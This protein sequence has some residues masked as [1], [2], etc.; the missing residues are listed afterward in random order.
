MADKTPCSQ[1]SG[2][3][4]SP[5]LSL[6]E[7]D[8]EEDSVVAVPLEKREI[9][10]QNGSNSSPQLYRNNDENCQIEEN[11]PTSSSGALTCSNCSN[12]CSLRQTPKLNHISTAEAR[13]KSYLVGCA[14]SWGSLLGAGQLDLHFPERQ[15]SVLVGTWNTNEIGNLAST[16]DDFLLPTCLKQ[17]PDVYAVGTQENVL[18]KQD[19]EVAMQEVIGLSHVLLHSTALGTLH[20]A[21]F[22]RRELIWFCSE[23]EE[24]TIATRQATAIKTKGAIAITLQV[25]GTSFLFINCHL[26]AHDS[27]IRERIL[28]YEKIR[29]GL[30]LPRKTPTREASA[31]SDV[32]SKFDCVF[33]LGDLNFRISGS[34][35]DV[36]A[37]LCRP[38]PDFDFLLEADQLK[39]T[40]DRGEAFLGFHEERIQFVPSYKYDVG[41]DLYDTSDKHRSPAYTDR[42]LYR[43]KAKTKVTCLHYNSV[44]T[45]RMSDHK[46]VFAVFL[47]QLRPGRD[48]IP[49]AAGLF[50]RNVYLRALARRKVALDP[51]A[52]HKNSRLCCVM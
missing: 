44:P 10:C 52:S 7:N 19:W 4:S 49:L 41:T 13:T 29:G 34:R 46:P 47:V 9:Q 48:D 24:S 40:M 30:E 50:N 1:T 39:I 15:L 17:I 33:W 42:I 25:F 36:L 18:S 12:I 20:L 43:T 27:N 37:H 21:I 3:I 2:K 6:E 28:D 45:V 16:L 26:T 32:T 5:L 8:A 35:S 23:P 11:S 22:I 14:N 31:I 38:M 51:L